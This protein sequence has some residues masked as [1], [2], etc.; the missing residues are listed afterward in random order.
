MHVLLN[1]PN[2]RTEIIKNMKRNIYEIYM[3]NVN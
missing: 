1:H 3:G 2:F